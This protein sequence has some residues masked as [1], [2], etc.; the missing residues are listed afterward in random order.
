MS[1]GKFSLASVLVDA[2]P[3]PA[4]ELGR[5]YV[6]FSAPL[7]DKDPTLK[8]VFEDWS[9]AFSGLETFANAASQAGNGF[10]K[11]N[12]ADATLDMPIR[13]PNKLI[14]MGANFMDHLA[15]MGLATVKYDPMPIF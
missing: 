3:R 11:I 9:K 6:L 2:K 10:R 14:G 12:A 7:A 4:V 15:E 8:S 13:F 5:E 1:M